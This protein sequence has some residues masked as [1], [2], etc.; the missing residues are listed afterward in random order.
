MADNERRNTEIK[1]SRA[2]VMVFVVREANIAP[3]EMGA[4]ECHK[5]IAAT[6]FLIFSFLSVCFVGCCFQ[7]ALIPHYMWPLL[8]GRALFYTFF[9]LVILIAL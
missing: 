3:G 1:E 9:S 6:T 5:P 7:S 4:S 2:R 8:V